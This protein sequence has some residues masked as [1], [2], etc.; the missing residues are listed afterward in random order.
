M[1]I[2]LRLSGFYLN[3]LLSYSTL[4]NL[5]NYIKIFNLTISENAINSRIILKLFYSTSSQYV[6]FLLNIARNIHYYRFP[7]LKFYALVHLVVTL[8]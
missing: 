8:C 6:F 4:L 5:I 1:P 2:H 3:Y 7:C